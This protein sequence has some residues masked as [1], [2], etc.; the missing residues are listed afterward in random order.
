LSR[1]CLGK[2]SAFLKNKTARNKNKTKQNK[3]DVFSRSYLGEAAVVPEDRAV[4][5]PQ[6]ALLGV[7]C[8]YSS[9]RRR[10]IRTGLGEVR[11]EEE[12]EEEEISSARA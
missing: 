12:E 6:L 11:R 7:L 10:Q 8:G 9:R 3:E 1:A 5:I 2:P 4:V